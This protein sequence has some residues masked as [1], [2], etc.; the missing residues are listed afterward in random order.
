M[1]CY[2]LCNDGLGRCMAITVYIIMALGNLN[3]YLAV[4]KPKIG[5]EEEVTALTEY[6]A[7]TVFWLLMVASHVRTMCADPGFIP[8]GYKYKEEVLAAPF[9]TLDAVE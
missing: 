1:G 6:A 4:V 9:Q 7:Y 5:T 3:L 2:L 8:K